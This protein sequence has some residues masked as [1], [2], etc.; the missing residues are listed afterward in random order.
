VGGER[1]IPRAMERWLHASFL[2]LALVLCLMRFAFLKADFPNYSPWMVDQAKFTDEGWWASAA[3]RHFL[4]GNWQVA[5]DYNP[6]AAVPVWPVLLTMVFH[7]TGVSI[8]AARAVN[9]S[10][11]IATIALVYLLVRRYGG[12]GADG[13]GAETA[14]A[15]AAL[16]LAAS[17]FAFA[18]SRLAT[19]DTL[20]VFAFCL[21]L[22]VASYA[23]PWKIWPL[24]LLGILIPIMLLTKTTSAVLPP[25]VLWLL[26]ME[27]RQRPMR[28]LRAVLV[29]SALASVAMGIYLSVVLRSRYA[30]DYH[31]FFDINALADVEWERTAS[32]LLQ[33][34]RNS[35]WIDRILFPA[36]LAVLVLSLV[37][38]RQLWRNPL[39]AASWIAFAG[40][41]VYILRRQDD[42]APRYFLA[43]LVPLILVLVLTLQEVR[44]RHRAFAALLMA[45]LT[46]ALILDIARIVSF[47]DHR[48]YQFYGAAKSIQ[49]IVNKEKNAHRLLLGASGDQ[50]S[51][52]I[53]IPSINDEYSSED[54]A[55]KLLQYQ[56][57]WYVGWNEID[58]DVQASLSA[59]RLDKVATFRVFDN[60]QRDLLTLYRMV[61][62]KPSP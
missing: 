8:A 10:F 27:T 32:F 2:S 30:G 47:L 37:W 20:I 45:T 48:Q 44:V 24:L 17:P 31:Y 61:P 9:V 18:F 14:A 33:L 57:G 36:G 3:V 5:G 6:A 4:I 62:V 15:L 40:E 34:L 7:F 35:M 28:F 41:A 60:D 23:D 19:L 29:V 26:W 39:F 56:P 22:W 59:F 54:L 50:L 52:M 25:A 16:L 1:E 11:S 13:F 43:M 53:G 51:L 49:A 42:Y 12:P 46:V 58:Q 38:L 55:Q 21:L